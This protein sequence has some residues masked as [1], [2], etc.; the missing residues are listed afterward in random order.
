[1]KNLKDDFRKYAVYKCGVNS[2]LLD[3]H[4]ESI[5]NCNRTVIEE[6]TTNFR[7]ID[8][9]SRL[10]MDRIIFL[11]SEI[12]S[13]VA[14]V[15]VAQMLY[16]DFLDT[17]DINMYINSP[18]GEIYAGLSIFDTM[19]YIKSKVNT[20]CTGLCASMAAILLAGGEKGHRYSLKH[21]RI[22]IHQPSSGVKGQASEMEIIMKEV[23]ALKKELYEI[24]AERTG[25]DYK[26]IEK[27]ADRDHWMTAEEAKAYGIIDEI[28]NKK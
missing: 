28:L 17:K 2:L 13:N 1:M 11:G 27:D 10:I 9:F 22:M 12:N 24:L 6:R 14:N 15:L 20:F 19:A 8:V 7:E 16:L 21:S 26:I 4:I 25:K 23:L 5:E 18:G 3:K